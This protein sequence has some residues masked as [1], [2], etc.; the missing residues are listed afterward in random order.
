M[1]SPITL[2]N[3]FILKQGRDHN[4]LRDRLFYIFNGTF[5]HVI[6]PTG[7]SITGDRSL[8]CYGLAL[9]LPK[10]G[11]SGLLVAPTNRSKCQRELEGSD[12]LDKRATES[13]PPAFAFNFMKASARR[14]PSNLRRVSPRRSSN[15]R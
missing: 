3:I 9:S 13:I 2:K 4:I 12:L 15:R 7:L 14:D 10:G 1:K 11:K 8:V 6:I 5:F